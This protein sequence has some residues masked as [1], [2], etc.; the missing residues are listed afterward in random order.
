MKKPSLKNF[1]VVISFFYFCFLYTIN[2]QQFR[3]IET[4]ANIGDISNNNGVAI[5]D[6]DQDNDLDIFIV[7]SQAFDENDSSTWSRLLK[8][9]NDG[10]FEDVTIAS[11]IEQDFLHEITAVDAFD[12]GDKMSASWGDYNNDGY[13]DLFL[14]NAVQSQLYKNNGNGTF[15]NVTVQAGFQET[16]EVCYMTGSLWWDY[17]NDGHLDLYISDYNLISDNKLY[18]NL[19]NGTFSLIS[20]T[21]LI[22][23]SNSLSAIPIDANGDQY[24]DLYVANDFY[25]DNWL[26]INQNGNGFVEAA[27]D[28]N[29]VDPF[30]G[31][32]L[33]TCDFNNNGLEDLLI[34]NIK[35]NGFYV[36]NG[37]GPFTFYSEIAGIYDTRW[38]WGSVFTDFDHDGYEDLFIVNGFVNEEKNF[39][40]KNIPDG[41]S[42]RFLHSEMTEEPIEGSNSRS[43]VA[44]DFDNDGDE[45]IIHTNFEGH[46]FLYENTSIDS[47]FTTETSG[48]W[49]KVKLEGV[50]SNKDGLG[51]KIE[52]QTNNQLEQY[53]RYHGSGYQSQSIKPIHFG[54]G[55]ADTIDNISVTW[56]TG[57]TE[58]YENIPINS[59]IKIIEGSGYT[60]ID[61]NTAIKIPGCTIEDSCSYDENAT[62]N[63]NSCTYLEAGVISGNQITNPL[64][65]EEYTYGPSVGDIYEWDI[66]NGE[67]IDGQ[68]TPT[69]TVNWNVATQGEVS[70]VNRN[71][72]C[73]TESVVLNVTIEES[74]DD[75]ADFSI[76]R[77]WN[78]VLL[79]AI[80]KDFARPTIHARN[81]FHVSAAMYDSWAIYDE[82]ASPYFIG[83]EVNGFAI[84]FEEF[85]PSEDTLVSI[86]KTLSYASYR[87]LKHRFANSP[88]AEE[89]LSKFDDLMD[90]LDYDINFESVNYSTGNP[91]SLG[92]YIASKIIE[93]G[94]QDGSNEANAY[95]NLYYEPTNE[96]LVPILPGNPL[97]TDANRWQPLALEVFID[98]SGNVV[99]QSTP[100]FLS[101]EWGNSYP[102]SLTEDVLTTYSRDSHTYKV[103]HDPGAPPY[104]GNTI[105]E[106][107][108]Y[109][110][111]FSLVSIWSAHLDSSD[112]VL[113]DI[114]PKSIGNIPLSSFPSEFE[115]YSDFYD[116]ING[117][118][119]SN[120]RNINPITG[121]AYQ[122]QIVPRGDYARVLAE[123]WA[124]GPDSETPPG[125]WY[126]LL[127]YVSDHPLLEKR[128]NGTGEILSNLEWDV[129]TYFAL[130]GA[131]HDSA[132]AAWGIK[133]WYDYIRPISSIR[134][135]ADKGQSTDTNLDNYHPDG[136]PLVGNY[137]EVVEES[138]ELSGINNEH[139]GKIK[140]YTW[141]GHDYIENVETDIAGVGWI[142]AENWWPYQRPSFVTPPFAGYVS[143]HSTYSR[144]AAEMMTKLTG[145]EFFPGGLGEFEAKQNEFLVFEEGPSQ[146]IILQWAT[147]RDASDQ[148]S[149]SRIWGGIHPPMDD[150]PGRII[151]EQIGLDA[152]DLAEDYF[153]GLVEEDITPPFTN[154]Q[155]VLF[156]NPVD[157]SN[158]IIITNTTLNNSFTLSDVSGKKMYVQQEFIEESNRTRLYINNLAKGMYLLK[159]EG[160]IWKIIVK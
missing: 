126:V 52:L 108:I 105:S 31:M 29:V 121:L 38:S 122:E 18:E 90:L 103:F 23:N 153:N 109:K 70:I 61:T 54:F 74:E 63:D 115:N 144:A 146:D 16:C 41:D 130:G 43:T 67:I 7:G 113:W 22:G 117:G 116:L 9:N 98:Q 89:T 28:Y 124:D 152:F 12:I 21:N 5:A 107:D 137:I 106:S 83:N 93:F 25:Q 15:D 147:Y 49:L 96:A 94:L 154:D 30:D 140:L 120:G 129:K 11:G 47:Y 66:I 150:I 123:F 97:I 111:G 3:R 151:G 68:G 60:I 91:A 112:G 145:T 149:L 42:R 131:M 136:I 72:A 114:S 156:P 8:N 99:N 148:C 51:S 19:G 92:N 27:Q 44:F 158:S 34:T 32:G 135:M 82:T 17:D 35:E 157:N 81:L 58:T 50:T 33:S 84:D 160:E 85:T 65:N 159:T 88:N 55:N 78:E 128:I 26:L 53:R 138:D 6:F 37:T 77:L 73:A 125:H 4:Q 40:F 104:I 71:E 80:R 134:Y 59:T 102:F 69:I 101:P 14:A 24:L 2:A 62:V 1:L 95:S 46:I 75:G 133:G 76:A 20:D 64:V 110:W 57:V 119:I 143:G 39:Y 141:R 36:N 86:N 100:D 87:I 56:P 132:I 48:G 155:M 139:V 118:D 10:S 127:N 79:D 13:P 142:L 45:D